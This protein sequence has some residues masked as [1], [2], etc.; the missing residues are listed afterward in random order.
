MPT[1]LTITRGELLAIARLDAA[2]VQAQADADY[3]LAAKQE[4]TEETVEPAALADLSVRKL[5]T[6]N[7][8][9]LLAADLIE[10]RSREEGAGGALSAAGVEIGAPP[11][12]AAR[13]REEARLALAPYRVPDDAVAATQAKQRASADADRARYVATL[14]KQGVVSAEEGRAFLG[15]AAGAPSPEAAGL[16][17]AEIDAR[18]R[19]VE[20][21]RAAGLIAGTEAW[22]A[23]Y[24]G[25]PE[26]AS[27]VASGFKGVAVYPV[28]ESPVSLGA[29]ERLFG[30]PAGGR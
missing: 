12:H 20:R 21:L 2:D 8:A 28:G 3:V 5:L 25:L 19:L 1:V 30:R 10:M 29:Q 9:K 26:G 11:D 7:V 27:L 6:R 16:S 22:V 24:L 18:R 17:A 14:V 4:G 15:M 23:S 13:L